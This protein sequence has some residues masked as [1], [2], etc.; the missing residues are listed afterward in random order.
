MTTPSSGPISLLDIQN[1]FGGAN[2]IGINEYYRGGGRIPNSAS[3]NAVPTSGTISL[4]NFYNLS[5]VTGLSVEIL[6]VAGGGGTYSDRENG[7]QTGGGGG[8]GTYISSR[9]L[10][11]GSYSVFIGAGG[12]TNGGDTAF[13]GSPSALGGGGSDYGLPA[14]AGGSGGGGSSGG[15]SGGAGTPGQ[16]YPGG[17]GVGPAG[18]G[19][20]GGAL[21]SGQ[22]GA[23]ATDVNGGPGYPLATFKGPGSPG[24]YSVSGTVGQG[25][26]T[27]NTGTGGDDGAASGSGARSSWGD[28]NYGSGGI[29]IVRYLSP[30]GN[31][32]ATGGT[33][34]DGAPGGTTYKYHEFTASGTF[35]VT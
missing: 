18:G 12:G 31:F 7:L 8:G 25:G 34:Y 20:G 5:A 35:T 15:Y 24:Y 2:P 16:G 33:T 3:Y 4:N 23:P 32:L 9:S 6:M 11:P 30:L 21:G 26:G 17:S 13:T 29:L 28:T 19:G 14:Y 10:S 27:G 22:N 1:E